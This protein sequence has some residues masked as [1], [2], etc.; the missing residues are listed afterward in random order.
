[1]KRFVFSLLI[2]SAALFNSSAFAQSKRASEI[3]HRHN[4]KVNL[5]SSVI[6]FAPEISYEYITTPEGAFGIKGLFNLNAVQK[7]EYNERSF[8]DKGVADIRLTPYYR[9]YFF[10]NTKSERRIANGFYLEA[11]ASYA[12][13]TYGKYDSTGSSNSTE[14]ISERGNTFGLGVGIGG[15]FSTRKNWVFD[16]G[17]YLGRNIIYPNNENM[18]GMLYISIGKR[19]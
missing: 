17:G 2:L 8:W 5:L 12:H 7:K 16:F 15:Q 14:L 6:S 4:I 3:P 18:Y 10:G 13:L 9:W 11:N 1:M 19:F